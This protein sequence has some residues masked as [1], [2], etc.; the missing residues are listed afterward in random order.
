MNFDDNDITK[1]SLCPYRFALESIVQEKTIFRSRF[2]IHHYMRII[3]GYNVA[4]ALAGNNFDSL[5][6]KK[7]IIDEYNSVSDQ[8]KLSEELEKTQLIASVF[9]DI[10]KKGKMFNS[11]L[12]LSKLYKQISNS[13][14]KSKKP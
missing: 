13:S 5:I 9:K 4:K 11:F 2:L 14:K 10:K 12:F 1:I 8:F 7:K 6:V 3:I